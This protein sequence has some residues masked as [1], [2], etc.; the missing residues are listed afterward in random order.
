M[1]LYISGSSW[2]CLSQQ[3]W[4]DLLVIVQKE[5]RDVRLCHGVIES[6][7]YVGSNPFKCLELTRLWNEKQNS[8]MKQRII[9]QNAEAYT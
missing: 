1:L 5:V 6:S 8:Q 7:F 2:G 4:L 9:L 3:K